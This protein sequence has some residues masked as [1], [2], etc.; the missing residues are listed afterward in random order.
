QPGKPASKEPIVDRKGLTVGGLAKIIHSDFYKRFRYAKIWG[1]SAKFD[2]E[3]VGL[4]RL[5]SDGDTV[6][7]HA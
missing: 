5:L 6:Q 3:R 7:F 1:P 2:S 4:D